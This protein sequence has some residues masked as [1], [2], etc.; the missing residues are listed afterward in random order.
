MTCTL[1]GIKRGEL[2]DLGFQ[3][4]N[5]VMEESA[6]ILDVETFM[7]MML[8]RPD[9]EFGSR[10]KRVVLIGD[11]QQ[12]VARLTALAFVH[13]CSLHSLATFTCVF[14]SESHRVNRRPPAVGSATDC[15]FRVYLTDCSRHVY[16]CPLHSAHAN[17]TI[18][19]QLYTR[20]R[21]PPVIKNRAFQKFA[22]M[23]QSLFARLV[24]LGVN[25]IQLDAQVGSLTH[26]TD[27]DVT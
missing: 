8:Q 17:L 22:H 25:C 6:Q 1:A 26:V 14:S 18:N 15:S 24:R 23:D 12:W 27:V 5:L 9:A 7:P 11:H 16:S 13:L 4:D 3:Y 10:L 2:L 21:L 20:H 19:M